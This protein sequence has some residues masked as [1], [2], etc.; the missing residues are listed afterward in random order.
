MPDWRLAR[1]L[2][3]L[4]SEVRTLYPHRDTTSDG[5]VGDASH[6]ARASKH[7]PG[8]DRIVEAV[9]L[10]EDVDGRDD[11]AGRELWALTQ[12]IVALGKAGHPALGPGAHLIYEGRIWSQVRGWAERPY[13]GP[14]AHRRHLHVACSDGAGKDSTQ[15]W[16]L[17]ELRGRPLPAKG[18]RWLGLANPPMVGQDVTNVRNALRVAGNHDLPATGPYDRAV[19][20]LVQLFQRNRDITERG[21]GPQT[22]AAL[23]A[24][25]HG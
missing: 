14:N 3:T 8:P 1:S 7:N 24:A 18:D 10:D 17:P 16:R 11:E 4:R 9:D 25:V 20:D 12:H 2:T 5:S 6:G 19:T 22:W 21:V 13:T 15:S 23:R